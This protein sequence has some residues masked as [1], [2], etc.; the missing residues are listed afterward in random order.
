MALCNDTMVLVF[1]AYI[2]KSLRTDEELWCAATTIA[3]H[4]NSKGI[5][6]DII[7][8]NL[9]INFLPRNFFANM[10]VKVPTSM[11]QKI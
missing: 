6:S 4:T 7:L 11:C 1:E 3:T 5:L 9:G 2:W 8:A 10:F